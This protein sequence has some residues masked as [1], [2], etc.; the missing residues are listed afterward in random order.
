MSPEE[1]PISFIHMKQ[2]FFASKQ[3]G[4]EKTPGFLVKNYANIAEEY[5]HLEAALIPPLDGNTLDTYQEFKIYCKDMLKLYEQTIRHDFEKPN[6]SE[7]PIRDH[8]GF[9]HVSRT[10]LSSARFIVVQILQ[11]IKEAEYVGH[12]VNIS[13]MIDLLMASTQYFYMLS[14]AFPG[15]RLLTDLVNITKHAMYPTKETNPTHELSLAAR[16]SSELYRARFSLINDTQSIILNT[17]SNFP[18]FFNI[19]TFLATTLVFAGLVLDIC[20]LLYA[21]SIARDAFLEKKKQY[22]NEIVQNYPG[23]IR[24]ISQRQL[25]ELELGYCGIQSNLNLSL[26]GGS[27]ILAGF[28]LLMT[29]PVSIFAPIGGLCCLLGTSLYL[30][31]GSYAHY[32]QQN[33]I[34]QHKK[35]SIRATESDLHASEKATQNAWDNFVY[36]LVTN[37]CFPVILMGTFAASSPAA[38][39]LLIALITFKI[40]S[41]DPQPLLTLTY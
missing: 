36:P 8:I 14:I 13:K 22:D 23:I 21:Y 2:A 35:T 19:S 6:D 34:F 15:L 31:A 24:D 12:T 7:K 38:L 28:T 3:R 16:F 11:L 1:Q 17:L 29:A 18:E 32:E 10:M 30:T 9:A 40:Q 41:P 25:Q 26:L 20:F 39:L 33:F 37:L 5:K 27:V 4:A